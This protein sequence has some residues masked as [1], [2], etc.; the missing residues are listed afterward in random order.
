MIIAHF[1]LLKI[2]QN[3]LSDDISWDQMHRSRNKTGALQRELPPGAAADARIFHLGGCGI[4]WKKPWVHSSSFLFSRWSFFGGGRFGSAGKPVEVG[5]FFARVV[6]HF[7]VNDVKIYVNQMQTLKRYTVWYVQAGSSIAKRVYKPLQRLQQVARG[8]I[9]SSFTLLVLAFWTLI[10]HEKNRK[11][12]AKIEL[13][14]T[15]RTFF[16]MIYAQAM[17]RI[18]FSPQVVI[19]LHIMIPSL[20]LT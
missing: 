12:A 3:H 6:K 14:T 18:E 13:A 5:L 16:L 20:K 11:T 8:A 10:C 19:N 2:F 7:V 4:D 9:G 1:N 17:D 15:R